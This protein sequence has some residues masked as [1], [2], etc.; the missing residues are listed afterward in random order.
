MTAPAQTREKVYTFQIEGL[1]DIGVYGDQRGLIFDFATEEKAD[2]FVKKVLSNFGFLLQP[3]CRFYHSPKT[4]MFRIKPV[5]ELPTGF[6]D[7]VN[8]HLLFHISAAYWP[9]TKAKKMAYKFPVSL[10]PS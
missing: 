3:Y 9:D 10:P 7:A 1:T 4:V 2:R 5:S 8:D 6:K